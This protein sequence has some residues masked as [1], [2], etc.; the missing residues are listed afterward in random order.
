MHQ[1]LKWKWT[2]PIDK[3]WEIPFGLNGLT[4]FFLLLPFFFQKELI[5]IEEGKRQIRLKRARN[6]DVWE[7][8]AT[9]PEDWNAPTVHKSFSGKEFSAGSN[10]IIKNQSRCSI[11]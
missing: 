9:P 10:E 5:A 7:Y 8:R 2:G 11:S 4:C 3:E 6:N 1:P